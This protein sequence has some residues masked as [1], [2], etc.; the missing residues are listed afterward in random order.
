M[1][2]ND[3]QAR[4]EHS[5]AAL[6][7]RTATA[8]KEIERRRLAVDAA[9]AKA[10]AAGYIAPSSDD[11]TAALGDRDGLS[12]EYESMAV[13]RKRK[14]GADVPPAGPK[15]KRWEKRLAELRKGLTGYAAND[16][17]G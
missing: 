10:N 2:P 11:L 16:E 14:A 15:K 5:A 7:A 13:N 1:L 3:L 8:R 9:R 4:L 6:D 12:T 17:E